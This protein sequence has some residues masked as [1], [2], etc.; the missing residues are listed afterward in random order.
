MLL[1]VLCRPGEHSQ[2]VTRPVV[3]EC[4]LALAQLLWLLH[5]M[6]WLAQRS[7]R[8]QPVPLTAVLLIVLLEIGHSGQHA[9]PHAVVGC[10]HALVLSP[11]LPHVVVW[12]ALHSPK[13]RRATPFAAHEHANWV[14]GPV[15]PAA[16][17]RVAVAPVHA[18]AKLFC[19]IAVEPHAQLMG[20]LAQPKH[21]QRLATRS[22]VCVTAL[23]LRLA[24]GDH[25]TGHV[26][27]VSVSAHAPSTVNLSVV[28]HL[29]LSSIRP[30]HVHL[31]TVLLTV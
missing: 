13:I 18:H 29:A 9:L 22:A 8:F 31:R 25:V 12:D 27:V 7:A 15:G 23:T 24:A 19:L 5:A 17:L 1:T 16:H 30:V 3:E 26:G 10:K 2:R 28:A 6:G 21:K 4:K 11:H 20:W 14:N